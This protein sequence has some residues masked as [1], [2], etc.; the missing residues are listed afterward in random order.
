VTS[1]HAA[2]GQIVD[3]TGADPEL[4][5]DGGGGQHHAQKSDRDDG[6]RG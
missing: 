6:T 2:R 5:G 1:E 3:S 4:L